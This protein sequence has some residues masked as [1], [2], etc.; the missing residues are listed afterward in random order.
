[1]LT[2]N[3]PDD[4]ND[5]AHLSLRQA[6]LAVDSQSTSALAPQQRQQVSGSLGQNDRIQFAPGVHGTITLAQGE[7]D[8]TRSVVVAGPGAANLTIDAHRQGRVFDVLTTGINVTLDGLTITGGKRTSDEGGGIASVG[9]L[10]VSNCA[11][12][13]NSAYFGGGIA[14]G[15][16]LTVIN[17]ALSGNQADSGGGIRSVGMLTV[18]DCALSGNSAF[19]DGGGIASVG[20]LTVS[21]CSLSGNYAFSVGGGIE[22]RGTLTVSGCS[23]SGNYAFFDGGGIDSHG[24]LVVTNSTLSG[25]SSEFAGGG[26]ENAGTATLTSVTVTANVAREAHSPGS[27]GLGGG[28]Y[29]QSGTMLLHNSIVAGNFRGD[30]GGPADDVRGALSAN[31]SYDLIGT[32]GSGG[33]TNGVNHNLVGVSDARLAALAYHGGLT[34][35][36]AVLTGSPALAAGDP[37]LLG[38]TD[39]RGIVRT[40]A[41]TIGAYQDVVPPSGGPPGPFLG[42]PPWNPWNPGAPGT[43]HPERMM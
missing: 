12:S 7:L 14:S 1:V 4:G 42:Y 28:V 11:L 21:D 2:V 39:Q 5:P 19:F 10:T 26:L 6:I 24:T 30:P 8:I 32:G 41:V 29:N 9:T 23:L 20:T 33:L 31:S 16:T 37:S 36:C 18:R 25:N 40:G 15:G 22:S 13:G 17:C 27:D 38:T 43:P 34:L 35:T 3:I